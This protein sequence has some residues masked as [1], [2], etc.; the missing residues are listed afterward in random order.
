M[1]NLFKRN[2]IILIL[3]GLVIFNLTVYGGVKLI[4][5]DGYEELEQAAVTKNVQ[6]AL[7]AIENE[8]ENMETLCIDWAVWDD[9]YDFIES[10]DPEYIEANLLNATLIELNLNS[11]LFFNMKGELA[12]G[13]A[14]S[15]SLDQEIELPEE[16]IQKITQR[17]EFWHGNADRKQNGLLLLSDGPIF[18]SSWPI[19][20]SD[21][22][23]PP[24]GLLVMVRPLDSE[25]IDRLSQQT[26]LSL[27]MQ[28]F[29]NLAQ[30]S[31]LFTASATAIQIDIQGSDT[32]WGHTIIKDMEGDFIL[33]LS[34]KMH[35]GLFLQGQKSTS[36]FLKCFGLASC[37]FSLVLYLLIMK[38]KETHD[39]I[40]QRFKYAF[41]NNSDGLLV[42][43]KAGKISVINS[44]AE[45]LLGLSSPAKSLSDIKLLET[46][47]SIENLSR[48]DHLQ[49]FF[50]ITP[51]NP[52]HKQPQ[53]LRVK[54][55]PLVSKGVIDQEIIVSITDISDHK[56]LDK[57]KDELISTAAHE[58]STPLST[59]MGFTEILCHPEDFGHFSDQQKQDFLNEVYEKGES[60]NRIIGDLLDISRIEHGSPIPIERQETDILELLRKKVD[61][62]RMDCGFNVQLKVITPLESKGFMIDRHRFSQVLDNLLSNAIK[63]SPE[64]G[65]IIL[66]VCVNETCLEFQIEDNGMGMSEEQLEQIFNKFYRADSSNTAISGLGLGMSVAKQIVEAHGG[67]IKVES[68]LGVGTTTIFTLPIPQE[69]MNQAAFI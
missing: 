44:A 52:K 25:A 35:R 56:T 42:M 45:R 36:F 58:L 15:L 10:I 21:G 57:M 55:I 63:Y 47:I 34:V 31:A 37:I 14:R 50:D 5:A 11:I 13:K 27:H 30:P 48:E 7:N 66:K 54:I 26:Q 9:T 62:L 46:Y 41:E 39:K 6:R 1:N 2:L 24:K 18:F 38:N 20:T 4:L 32:I 69:D 28:E 22:E 33:K 29:Q 43:N 23:G 16:L 67:D 59:M 68:K 17:K 53:H 51:N 3:S 65:A 60:L 12:F 40:E 8:L 61:F 49:N 64:G 19:L